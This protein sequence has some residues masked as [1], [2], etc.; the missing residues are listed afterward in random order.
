MSESNSKNKRQT[1]HAASTGFTLVELLVV[2]TIIG[3]LIALLLPAVQ[4]AREAARRMQCSNNLKQIGLAVLNYESNRTVL[5]PGAF[6]HNTAAQR[7]GSILL[8]I[9]PYMELQSL[10]DAFNFNLNTDGQSYTGTTNPIGATPVAAY[11]CPSDTA[12]TL[13][14]CTDTSN[15]DYSSGTAP[16]ALV[17][18]HNYAASRGA[19]PLHSNSPSCV[20]SS[21]GTWNSFAL[22][23]GLTLSPGIPFSGPFY[24]FGA[25]LPM[26]EIRDGLSNTIF[27][28]EV[29]P[30]SSWHN[31][32]GWATSNNGNGYASTVVPINYDTSNRDS[33]GDACGRY[34]NYS[35]AEGF[36]SNHSGGANFVLGDGSVHFLPE[37]IDHQAYQRL[38]ARADGEAAS[39]G[40]Y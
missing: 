8:Q 15:P 11:R 37:T 5:P 10:Y 20:C 14:D 22:P 18:L 13:F 16:A 30:M 12:P 2:I 25:C 38:G 9:L 7:R 24:R 40:D 32:H 36:K 23:V 28:G 39:A 1:A 31:G 4:A 26:A 3:I 33:T 35:T 17:A 21:A 27:F 19:N 29:L 34:C 6:F